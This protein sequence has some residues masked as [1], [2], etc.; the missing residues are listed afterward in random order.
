MCCFL[1]GGRRHELTTLAVED[2][3]GPIEVF[4][5]GGCGGNTS[6]LRAST[7]AA[8]DAVDLFVRI[9]AN[10]EAESSRT[11]AEVSVIWIESA[12]K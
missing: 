9:V 1:R 7:L 4:D 5:Q 2:E 10:K 11:S 6:R 3:T 8:G 12:R